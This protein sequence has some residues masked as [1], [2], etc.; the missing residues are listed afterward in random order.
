MPIGAR[1]KFYKKR[2]SVVANSWQR[3]EELL[4][5]APGTTIIGK[6][7]FRD[8]L[9]AVIKSNGDNVNLTASRV[10]DNGVLKI[11]GGVASEN[12]NLK[13]CGVVFGND[14]PFFVVNLICSRQDRVS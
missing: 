11:A 7:E 1:V 6:K 9:G 2:N 10:D 8:G 12:W 14:A 3:Y 13:T 5:N 4:S